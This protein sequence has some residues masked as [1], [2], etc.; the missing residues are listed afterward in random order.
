MHSYQHADAAAY[1]PGVTSGAP[2]SARVST[3]PP[4][5]TSRLTFDY[6]NLG[7][8]RAEP[9]SPVRHFASGCSTSPVSPLFRVPIGHRWSS[10]SDRRP[11]CSSSI[12]SRASSSA[13]E[14]GLCPRHQH[15]HLR[16]GLADHVVRRLSPR[17]PRVTTRSM[18]LGTSSR[19]ATGPRGRQ[20]Q[21]RAPSRPP[22]RRRPPPAF[23]R[24]TIWPPAGRPTSISATPRAPASR[25]RPHLRRRR[26]PRAAP[27]TPPPGYPPPAT[28]TRRRSR[29]AGTTR[30][31]R[32]RRPGRRG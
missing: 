6:S 10:S 21:P 19:F 2:S 20:P 1:A 12:R 32:C 16:A 22:Q 13:R 23:G 18:R 28:T 14:M 24:S 25:R 7:P 15:G 31:R 17:A 26:H 29:S 11:G 8:I 5:S 4:R 27:P 30:R 9:L 3:T